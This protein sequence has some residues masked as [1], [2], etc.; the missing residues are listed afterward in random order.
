MTWSSIVVMTYFMVSKFPSLCLMA[1]HNDIVGQC[2]SVTD[3]FTVTKNFCFHGFLVFTWGRLQYD[4]WIHRINILNLLPGFCV[5]F[6][7]ISLPN[8][9]IGIIYSLIVRVMSFHDMKGLI[10]VGRGGGSGGGVGGLSVEYYF[11]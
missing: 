9:R 2:S 1:I 10:S 6:S 5:I 4:W 8:S 11:S 3:C 7:H